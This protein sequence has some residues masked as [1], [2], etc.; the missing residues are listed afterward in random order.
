MDDSPDVVA[1]LRDRGNTV[2]VFD[3]P[4]NRQLEGPRAETWTDVEHAVTSLVAERGIPLQAALPGLDD[5]PHR[6]R[7]RLSG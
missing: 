6:L 1:A 3:A 7:G 2:I 4:Y 5:G